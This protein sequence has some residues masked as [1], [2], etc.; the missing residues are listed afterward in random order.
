MDG[1]FLFSSLDE[2]KIEY[3]EYKVPQTK[4]ILIKNLEEENDN[5]VLKIIISYVIV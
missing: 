2:N 4:R 3:Y 1:E 5:H